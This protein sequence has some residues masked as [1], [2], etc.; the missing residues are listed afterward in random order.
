M[1]IFLKNKQSILFSI[2]SKKRAGMVFQA[3][4]LIEIIVLITEL[5]KVKK[6]L[7]F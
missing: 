5:E 7:N 4:F 3:V 2:P 6:D 1:D